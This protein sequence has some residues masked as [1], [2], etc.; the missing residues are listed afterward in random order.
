VFGIALAT[1]AAGAVQGTAGSFSGHVTVWTV[2]GLTAL[3][4]A[5]A[6]VFV[7]KTA[8]GDAAE[9]AGAPR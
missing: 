2:C 3:A 5:F 1:H 6:L 7:P 9:T 4:A 8:F